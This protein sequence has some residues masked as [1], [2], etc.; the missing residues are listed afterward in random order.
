METEK[1]KIL[2]IEDNRSYLTALTDKLNLEGFT[3]RTA[4]DGEK[5]LNL[6]K[7]EHPDLL[8]ID[9]MLPKMNGITIMNNLRQ[10]NWGQV[11][12]IIVLTN[13]SPD[14]DIIQ[15][16]MENQPAYYLIK[17]QVSLDEILTKIKNLLQLS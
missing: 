14:D 12:P 4:E 1:K 17:S 7:T 16:I 8:L 11:L 5:G 9:I 10:E 2:I 6:A 13:L 3:V 15:K